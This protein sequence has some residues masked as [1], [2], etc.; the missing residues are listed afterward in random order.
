MYENHISFMYKNELLINQYEL[1]LASKKKAQSQNLDKFKRFSMHFS[2]IARTPFALMDCVIWKRDIWKNISIF[3]ILMLE[4]KR[5]AG[6]D[7]NSFMIN[8]LF[9]FNTSV[10]SFS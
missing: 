4:N 3:F 8:L 2:F 9:L 5:E 10:S 6:L 7:E 1:T